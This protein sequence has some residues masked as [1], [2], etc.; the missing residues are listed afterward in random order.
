MYTGICS[1]QEPDK[2]SISSRLNIPASDEVYEFLR[3][4]IEFQLKRRGIII[5]EGKPQ[6]IPVQSYEPQTRK[7]KPFESAE[8]SYEPGWEKH[9]HY[10]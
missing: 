5:S 8:Q 1:T 7:L 9:Q 4:A 6:K 10:G 2:Q 3:S